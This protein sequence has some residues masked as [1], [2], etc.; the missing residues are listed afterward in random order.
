[1]MRQSGQP[2][3]CMSGGSPCVEAVADSACVILAPL[4]KKQPIR[5]TAAAAPGPDRGSA[6][7][8]ALN[9]QQWRS[10]GRS[11]GNTKTRL[12]ADSVHA[13]GLTT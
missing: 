1:M 7:R 2:M 5:E 6:R 11:M 3:N 4:A 13:F 12:I 10:P 8:G 9:L